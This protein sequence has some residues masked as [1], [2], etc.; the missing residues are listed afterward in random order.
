MSFLSL[1]FPLNMVLLL[2][3]IYF[4][5]DF[6]NNQEHPEAEKTFSSHQVFP[7]ISSL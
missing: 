3:Y 4:I 5:T 7:A 1:L 6:D 2:I